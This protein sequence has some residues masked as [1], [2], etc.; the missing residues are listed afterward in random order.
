M[1][2]TRDTPTREF[3]AVIV[4]TGACG[5]FAAK[6]LT[7]R[8]LTVLVLD[9]GP[10]PEPSRDFARHEWPWEQPSRGLSFQRRRAARASDRVPLM[11]AQHPDHPHSKKNVRVAS[12][13]EE[14]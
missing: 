1:E 3:D 13:L 8:G 2:I 4:G 9:A 10:M 5:G 14:I 12:A 7:E 6:E 11:W